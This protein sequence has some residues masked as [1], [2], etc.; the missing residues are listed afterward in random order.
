MPTTHTVKSGDTVSAIALRA[1]VTVEAI[2]A[3]NPQIKDIDRIEVGQELHIPD[4]RPLVAAAGVAKVHLVAEGDSLS[5]IAEREG[6]SLAEVLAANP[7]ITNPDIIEV[8]QRIVI[9]AAGSVAPARV[10]LQTD[11]GEIPDTPDLVIGFPRL[12]PV[13]QAAAGEFRADGQ[14]MA[15][16]VHQESSFKNFRVHGDGTGHG[17]I[18]LDDHGLLPAFEAW[19]GMAVGRGAAAVSIP[20]GLQMRFLAR[21]IAELTARHGNAFA[22]AREWHAGRGGMNGPAGLHYEE[23]IRAHIVKLFGGANG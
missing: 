22:A 18:G 5:Q 14:V 3:A 12:W 15:G 16:I 11:A 10:R 7:E 13:I 21:T 23:L 8:G 6:V 4:S 17:L 19:S 20:P 1:G 9:P 2:K